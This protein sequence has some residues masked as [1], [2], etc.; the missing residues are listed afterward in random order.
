MINASR[1]AVLDISVHKNRR[2]EHRGSTTQQVW[3][4]TSGATQLFSSELLVPGRSSE[5]HF[6]ICLAR[7]RADL[8]SREGF[9]AWASPA[10]DLGAPVGTGA[11]QREFRHSICS[12]VRASRFT[13]L[14]IVVPQ[15][16]E[17]R[18]ELMRGAPIERARATTVPRLI[19]LGLRGVG[20]DIEALWLQG[21]LS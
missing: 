9:V 16:C 19:R 13:A 11:F 12:S 14:S 10:P 4:S 7:W 3:A 2:S 6:H 8:C 5:W 20:I 21:E 15:G 1:Y 18:G 17:P